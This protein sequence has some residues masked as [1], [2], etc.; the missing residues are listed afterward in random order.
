MRV[1]LGF[2]LRFWVRNTSW[3][4]LT[5]LVMGYVLLSP[6]L[7][8]YETDT[9]PFLPYA[10]VLVVF[11]FQWSAF[12]YFFGKNRGEFEYAYLEHLADIRVPLPYLV[13]DGE[14]L[15]GNH[16]T[17]IRHAYIDTDR[18]GKDT[19]LACRVYLKLADIEWKE[20]NRDKAFKCLE[21]ARTFK[22]QDF[23]CNVRL[24]QCYEA[25]GA[26]N[27]AVA[28]YE[29]ALT[30]PSLASPNLESFVASQIERVKTKGPRKR[31]PSWGYRFA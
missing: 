21:L 23:V 6:V 19:E 24:G 18:I 29:A 17:A 15:L 20:D 13:T 25:T 11:I 22:P 26:S 30:D 16:Q 31:P 27:E 3:A 14:A 1:P 7:S 8:A 2:Y 4:A 5:G 12:K 9:E 10:A 28:A